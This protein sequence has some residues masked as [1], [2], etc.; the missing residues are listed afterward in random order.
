VVLDVPAESSYALLYRLGG[1]LGSW[2]HPCFE[3][4]RPDAVYP[5][6]LAASANWR[7]TP[8]KVEL[9]RATG[10]DD[11]VFYQ[12][13]TRHP[14]YSNDA[15]EDPIEGYDRGDYVAIRARKA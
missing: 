7:T 11:F 13:L 4:V 2:D 6:A 15:I 12:T 3:G 14:R 9:L 1:A 8:E 5:L 10:F